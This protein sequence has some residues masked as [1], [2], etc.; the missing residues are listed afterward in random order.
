MSDLLSSDPEPSDAHGVP[1]IQLLCNGCQHAQT[2]RGG[3]KRPQ[4]DLRSTSPPVLDIRSTVGCSHSRT[5][6]KN[7]RAAAIQLL[8]FW[9]LADHMTLSVMCHYRINDD[10]LSQFDDVM[11][12]T[13]CLRLGVISWKIHSASV[14][15]SIHS[16]YFQEIRKVHPFFYLSRFSKSVC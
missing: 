8:G 3:A 9:K 12:I 10:K 7:F 4:Q 1:T 13:I 6:Q 5:G 2:G 15:V 16:M 14:C 11:I